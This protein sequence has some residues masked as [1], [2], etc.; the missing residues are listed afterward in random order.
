MVTFDEAAVMLD[1]VAEEI[2]E[3]FYTRLNGGVN[4]LPR[5]VESPDSKKGRPLFILG[6]Y[7]SCTAMGKYINI[8]YGSFEKVFPGASAEEMRAELKRTL[9][10]EFTHHVETLA[11][12]RGLVIRDEIDHELY[13]EGDY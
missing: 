3:E 9:V 5:A 4:F 7:I 2:P 12:E 13:L 11:G 6:E 10:H 1:E 8:Y